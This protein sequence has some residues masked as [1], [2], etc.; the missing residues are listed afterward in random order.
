MINTMLYSN[1]F[2][3]GGIN[4]TGWTEWNDIHSNRNYFFRFIPSFDYSVT[5]KINK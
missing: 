1:R 5:V 4:N 2:A 3:I